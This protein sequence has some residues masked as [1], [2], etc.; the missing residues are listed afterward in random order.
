[1]EICKYRILKNKDLLY[2]G[3]MKLFVKNQESLV[4]VDPVS[5]CYQ[6]HSVYKW[7]RMPG[8]LICSY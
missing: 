7:M 8:M 4:C 5:E 2:C 1:M 6:D 3:I